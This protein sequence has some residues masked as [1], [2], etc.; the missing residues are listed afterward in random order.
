MPIHSR[1]LINVNE[2]MVQAIGKN[3]G[4]AIGITNSKIV[5]THEYSTK[6]KNEWSKELAFLVCHPDQLIN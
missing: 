5:T 4:E 2:A 3:N 1:C 6:K